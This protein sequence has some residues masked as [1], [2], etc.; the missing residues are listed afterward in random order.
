MHPGPI[1]NRKLAKRQLAATDRCNE[2]CYH[3]P[4]VTFN[5]FHSLYGGGPVVVVN[6]YLFNQENLNPVIISYPTPASDE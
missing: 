3:I 4:K 2:N 1:N 5:F 6:D